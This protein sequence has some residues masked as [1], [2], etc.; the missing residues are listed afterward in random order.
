MSIKEMPLE[1]LELLT[2]ADIAYQIIKEEETSMTTADVFKVVCKL[3]KIKK[4]GYEAKVADFFTMLT[5]DRRFVL[6]ES[7]EWDLKELHT[8]KIEID[9][10][11]EEEIIDDIEEESIEN[12]EI[13]KDIELLVDINDEDF[14]DDPET[15]ELEDLVI[16]TEDELEEE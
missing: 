4:A 13:E 3:R 8:A 5:T 1:E 15:T 12:S 16:V 10:I 14:D 2:F 7:G 9:Q 11:I 6:L